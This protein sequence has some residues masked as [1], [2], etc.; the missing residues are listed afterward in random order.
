MDGRTFRLRP[1]KPEDAAFILEL[2]GDR[3][4][5]RYLNRGAGDLAAQHRWLDQYFEREGDYY[6]VIERRRDGS[7]EG[8]A[9][10]YNLDTTGQTAEWGRWILR[11]ASAAGLESAGLVYR[12]AFEKLHLDSVYCR[13]VAENRGV[14][15]IHR[16]FGMQHV[17]TLA[18]YF[19]LDGRRLDVVETRLTAERWRGRRVAQQA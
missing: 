16:R 6:F 15:E 18:S 14:I 11:P 4:R 7:P 5:G 12:V 17:A 2:R 19:E 8:T 10:I 3:Q 13:T 1:V 9:G